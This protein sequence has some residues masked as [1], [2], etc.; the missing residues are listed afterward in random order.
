[1]ELRYMDAGERAQRR[2]AAGHW[3]YRVTNSYVIYQHLGSRH[4]FGAF[5]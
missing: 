2:S 3:G 4:A 5:G 1:M